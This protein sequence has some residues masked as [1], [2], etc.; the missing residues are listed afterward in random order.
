[1]IWKKDYVPYNHNDAIKHIESV[2][3]VHIASV[4]YKFKYHFKHK[5]TGEEQIE[6]FDGR[7]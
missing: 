7:R 2:R 3:D 6:P 4:S 5:D 1:M